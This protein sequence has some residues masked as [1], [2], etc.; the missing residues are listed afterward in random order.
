VVTKSVEGVFHPEH[1]EDVPP[2]GNP[3]TPPGEMGQPDILPQ[4]DPGI[5]LLRD[6]L[7][8]SSQR[9]PFPQPFR[10]RESAYEIK[11]DY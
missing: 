9:K 5:S 3:L 4:A 11:S 10:A 6:S 2:V 1:R 7:C 8:Q